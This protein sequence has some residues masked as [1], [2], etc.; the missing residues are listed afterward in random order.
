MRAWV[1]ALVQI[2]PIAHVAELTGLHWHTISASTSDVCRPGTVHST[3]KGGDGR[4]RTAQG[5]PL[6][7][8]DHECPVHARAVG[9]REQQSRGDPAILRIA[10]QRGL[11]AHRGHCD[12]HEHRLR[13]GGA[14][15]LPEC[16]GGLRSVSRRRALWS[17]SRR[18][19]AGRSGQRLAQR[20]DP[21]AGDQALALAAAT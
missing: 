5:T 21:T 9:W 4:V 20:A 13:S 7:D 18:P 8:R 12:G 16:R 15:P 14:S 6:C 3:P 17:G 10:G 1:E 2:L 19:G 11:S